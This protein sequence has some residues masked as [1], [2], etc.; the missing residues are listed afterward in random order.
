MY[1]DLWVID[2]LSWCR[3]WLDP[4]DGWRT[5]SKKHWVE[6]EIDQTKVSFLPWFIRAGGECHVESERTPIKTWGFMSQRGK[7]LLGK[8]DFTFVNGI[9]KEFPM[10]MRIIT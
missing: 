10:G 5:P 7:S 8:S 3:V 2:I 4:P 1:K 9:G 6:R